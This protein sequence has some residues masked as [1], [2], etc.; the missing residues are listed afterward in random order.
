MRILDRTKFALYCLCFSE[1]PH[2][3]VLIWRRP[4]HPD[5]SRS[6]EMCYVPA[7][8]DVAGLAGIAGQQIAS[9][10]LSLPRI[11][12]TLGLKAY[13]LSVFTES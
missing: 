8:H 10:A 13:E 2:G 1:I 6:V 12:Q 9:P 11:S 4:H 5:S 3:E 7:V